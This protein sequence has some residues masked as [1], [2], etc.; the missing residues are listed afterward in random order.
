MYLCVSDEGDV[1]L[2][3]GSGNCAGCDAVCHDHDQATCREA[4]ECEHSCC[5]T[6]EQA[7]GTEPAALVGLDGCNCL[8]VLVSWPQPPSVVT[9]GVGLDATRLL[10]SDGLAAEHLTCDA[11]LIDAQIDVFCARMNSLPSH[12]LAVLGSVVLRC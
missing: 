5:G 7:P 2:D 3:S 4:A 11:I 1:C 9:S 6:H 10:A 12:S 8:H